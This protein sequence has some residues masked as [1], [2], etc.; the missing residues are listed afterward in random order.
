MKLLALAPLCW[1]QTRAESSSTKP[2]L[3]SSRSISILDAILDV[4]IPRDLTP[5]ATDLDL[6]QSIVDIAAQIPRYPELIEQGLK[7]FESTSTKSFHKPFS[8]LPLDTQIQ[9][10]DVAFKQPEMTLPRVFIERLR[11][12]AMTLYY[13]NSAA[14]EGMDID[15][16]IQPIGYPKHDKPPKKL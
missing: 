3:S 9:I 12:D 8:S 10:V 5:S 14:W 2:L 11:D 6:G 4:L 13:H 16:P 1:N 7:W 15:R